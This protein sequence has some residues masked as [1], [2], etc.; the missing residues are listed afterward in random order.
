MKPEK[1]FALEERAAAVVS[2]LVGAQS[3]RLVFVVG[4]CLLVVLA[5]LVR[6]VMVER[7]P[8]ATAPALEES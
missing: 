6:R 8:T 7:A 3:I 5:L 2:G 4:V 1:R